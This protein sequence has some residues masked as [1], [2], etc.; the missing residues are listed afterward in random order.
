MGYLISLNY[1]KQKKEKKYCKRILSH[2]IKDMLRKYKKQWKLW[3]TII[4]H[5]PI[6]RLWLPGGKKKKLLDFIVG[7]LKSLCQS[8]SQWTYKDSRLW[9]FILVFITLDCQGLQYWKFMDLQR[10]KSYNESH[11]GWGPK[12]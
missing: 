5:T 4:G 1:W 7:G 9:K 8:L 12:I 2:A 3:L 10:F 6:G 11:W